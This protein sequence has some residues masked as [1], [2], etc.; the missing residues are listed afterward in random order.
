[1]P[2]TAR[3]G[4]R[5]QIVQQNRVRSHWIPPF[6]L[7]AGLAFQCIAWSLVLV[8]AVAP[9]FGIELAWVHDV[10]L[11]WLT[12][13]A[14]A[15]LIHVIPGFTSLDW[16]G[17]GAVRTAVIVAAVATLAL[18]VSFALAISAGVVIAAVSVSIALLVYA[19]LAIATLCQPASD[20]KSAA[21]ARGLTATQVALAL[22]A[23]MGTLPALGYA[24][25]PALLS[26]APSHAVL[27]IV[28]WLMLLTSG[29]SMRTFQPPHGPS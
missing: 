25:V 18:V 17:E 14:L 28:A 5:G 22:T 24:G 27:G 6:P 21:I 19:T 13:V 4:L 7:A 10:A 23:L 26:V 2:T 1:M 11:G 8:H 15:V 3:W 12:L 9:S 20:V 29:V 16:R